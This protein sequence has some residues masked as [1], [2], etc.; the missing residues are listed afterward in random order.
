MA[1]AELNAVIEMTTD[2]EKW[3]HGREKLQHQSGE[4][5][6]MEV[7]RQQLEEELAAQF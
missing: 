5:L 4:R 3:L 1:N 7:A 2:A 6:T